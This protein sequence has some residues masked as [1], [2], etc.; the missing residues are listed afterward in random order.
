MTELNVEVSFKTS[1]VDKVVIMQEFASV[2][3]LA[4]Q[5]GFDLVSVKIAPP[6]PPKPPTA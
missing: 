3:D 6:P 4:Q 2:I 1:M 5:K